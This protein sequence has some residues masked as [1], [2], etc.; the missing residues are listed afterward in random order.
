MMSPEPSEA[1][2][3]YGAA[4]Q[5]VIRQQDKVLKELRRGKWS[6][7]TDEAGDWTEYV[8]V[9]SGYAGS[10]HDPAKFRY[11]CDQLLVQVQAV[12]DAGVREDSMRCEA[13]IRACDPFLN[14]LSREFPIAAVAPPPRSPVPASSAPPGT[15]Q[16]R[17]P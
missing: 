8:R 2:T 16:Q 10:T 12:R 5:K 4:L 3:P 7:V 14:G 11:Y 1:V 13:A 15:R 17:V 9:L 6:Q